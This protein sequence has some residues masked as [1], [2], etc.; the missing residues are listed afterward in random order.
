[1][2]G[3]HSIMANT[4][5]AT[6][7]V[8]KTK[9]D[10]FSKI[11]EEWREKVTVKIKPELEEV[12]YEKMV[13]AT[14]NDY[15][16][17]KQDK[18]DPD[19]IKLKGDFMKD[20]ELHKNKSKRIIPIALE[21]F[22]VNNIPIEETIKNHKNIY[23]FCIRQK[24]S[25]DF[26][27]EGISQNGTNI[28]KKLIRYYVSLEGEKLFKIKNPECTTNAADVSIIEKGEICKVCNHLPKNTDPIAAGVNF[29]YYIEQCQ[30]FIDK[31]KLQGKK[32]VKKQPPN[33]ISLF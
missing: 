31:I 15:L 21:K 7:L 6:F 10:I 16:A 3:I 1:L 5:G 9:Y 20:F 26:H 2:N 27:Y 17:I 30:E 19:R 14:V 28:Y 13:F 23:D 25:R 8:P 18:N 11:K 33:Q 4:D 29:N 32:A 22:Y 24:A 12:K